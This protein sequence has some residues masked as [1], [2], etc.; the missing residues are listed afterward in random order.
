M[1]LEEWL[2][3]Y[4]QILLD[5]NFSRE[6]DEK[7]AKLISKLGKGRLLDCKVLEFIKGKEV[8]VIGGAYEGEKVEEELVITAGKA[9]EKVGFI[10]HIHVTDLEESLDRILEL[11]KANCILVFHA[12]GDNIERIKEVVPR[13]KKFIAT[14][15]YKPF[16]KV[17]NFGGF[18]DGDRAA[19]IAK[20]FGA[21]KIALY[22]FNF[23]K[24]D[25]LKLKKLKWAKK[26]LEI[27][28]ILNVSSQNP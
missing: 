3:I 5:F 12:H 6:M 2:K 14:T 8:A 26:I 25:I 21:K 23:E 24:G 20:R 15:Q 17:Y 4:E 7:S 27:E 19:L 18:T 1:E 13:V 16:D 11:E 28:G 22:G 9:V 10:P